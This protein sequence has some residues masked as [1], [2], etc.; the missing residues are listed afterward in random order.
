MRTSDSDARARDASL[1]AAYAAGDT[2][3]ARAILTEQAPRIL[4]LARR[5]LGGQEAEAEEVTQEALIRLWRAAPHWRAGEAL[6]STW[7]YRVAANLCTDRLRRRRTVPLP[8]GHDPP[9]DRPGP[10]AGLQRADRAAALAKALT[11]LPE[12]QRL[13]VVLRHLEDRP[14]PEIAQIMGLSVEA[15]E[16]LQSRGRRRLRQ[17]LDGAWP[18]LN[19]KDD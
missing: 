2:V 12:R 3:A 17:L 11:A 6:I 13:A 1:L 8:E 19:Y 14:N 10:Q 4:A 18:H 16:S 7:L 9:D 5:M 15:V